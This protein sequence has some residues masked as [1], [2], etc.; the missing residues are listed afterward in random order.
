ML[1]LLISRNYHDCILSDAEARK[2]SKRLR[3]HQ[4]GHDEE[5]VSASECLMSQVDQNNQEHFFIATQD[6][7][8]QNKIIRQPAGAVLFA[9]VNGIQMEMPSEK[10]KSH[11]I[12][13]VQKKM[14]PGEV[15]RQSNMVESENDQR[16]GM[17][18]RGV[19]KAK[20]PN[21]LS[22]KRKKD[23]NSGHPPLGDENTDKTTKKKSSRVRKSRIRQEQTTD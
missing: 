21:P 3:V 20:G 8:L 15:E 23:R 18:Y 14:M 11:V 9:T 17:R 2:A 6:R 12:Q 1:L 5:P 16:P 19:K 10:Q 22:M 13:Q 7:N 4:C